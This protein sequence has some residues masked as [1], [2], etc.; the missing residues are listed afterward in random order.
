MKIQRL[1][2]KITF[3]ALTLCTA[4]ITYAAPFGT[5]FTYQGRLNDAGNPANGLYDFKFSLYDANAAGSKVN[6]DV[7]ILDVNVANGYFTAKLDFGSGVFDGNDRWLEIGLRA[8]NLNDP[9]SYTTLSPRQEITPAPYALYAKAVPEA[10]TS[11]LFGAWVDKSTSY[12]TQQA[13]TDGFVI[14]YGTMGNGNFIKGFT[15]SNTDPTTQRAHTQSY[16]GIGSSGASYIQ[17]ITMP[18]KKNDYWKIVT[19]TSPIT[20]YWIPLGN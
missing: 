1:P 17:T 2:L 8:G 5:A 14:A 9:N 4:A 12:G 16:G 7:N 13:I 3:L 20:V 10:N 15:D 6:S 19:S 11:A 18:V